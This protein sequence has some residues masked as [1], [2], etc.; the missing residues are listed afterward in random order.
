MATEVTPRKAVWKHLLDDPAV[1]ALVGDRIYYQTRP[2]GA[3]YPCV[4]ISTISRMPRRDLDGMAWAETRLQ[5]TAMDTTEPGAEAVAKA[6]QDSLD[7]FSSARMAGALYV[8]ECRVETA[9]PML[10]EDTGQT[11]YHV[12]VVIIHK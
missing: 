5:V 12:D 6:I 3:A 7:G 8:M 1:V 10:Q 4:V 11:H 9:F 2:D